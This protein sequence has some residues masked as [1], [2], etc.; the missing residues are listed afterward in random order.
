MLISIVLVTNFLTSSQGFNNLQVNINVDGETKFTYDLSIDRNI[1]LKKS[2]Y[3]SLLGDMEIEI[4]DGMVRVK[5][6]KSPLNYCSKQ[7]W[8]DRAGKPIVCLP[9]GVIVV[10]EGNKS[11]NDLVL[12][13]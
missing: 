11:D 2:D 10:I 7:G 8:I 9:N 6:E 13:S 4:K 3:P 12:P 5:S 1:V